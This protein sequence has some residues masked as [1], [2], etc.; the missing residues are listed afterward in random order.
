MGKEQ[1][2]V[3]DGTGP[4]KGSYQSQ[5]SNQGK[6]QAKGETCPASQRPQPVKPKK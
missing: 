4:Y 3:R 2:G 5:N 6:R 1:K